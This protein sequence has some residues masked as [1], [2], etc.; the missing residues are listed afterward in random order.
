MLAQ[1]TWLKSI[2]GPTSSQRALPLK[3]VWR[4]CIVRPRP[5]QLA[6][7]RPPHARAVSRAIPPR[8]SG[9]FVAP[10]APGLL[11][12][13][14]RR[15]AR[16]SPLLVLLTCA[17][18]VFRPFACVAHRSFALAARPAEGRCRSH[19]YC[20]T[21]DLLTVESLDHH[22]RIESLT[23]PR[24]LM[25]QG[26]VP[27]RSHL[28]LGEHRLSE[29]CCRRSAQ[30]RRPRRACRSRRHR[31][32]Q[33][34]RQQPWDRSCRSPRPRCRS[35]RS[36]GWHSQYRGTECRMQQWTR[37]MTSLITPSSAMIG[38]R[39]PRR[40]GDGEDLAEGL[41]VLAVRPPGHQGR[42]LGDRRGRRRGAAAGG[43]ARRSLGGALRS[44]VRLQASLRGKP[45]RSAARRAEIG[46]RVA[47]ARLALGRRA[48]RHRSRHR[49]DL[50]RR[51]RGRR[52]LRR[53]C[54]RRR[55]LRRRHRP[56]RR[57]QD[58]EF[59]RP[60][61]RGATSRGGR[62]RKPGHGCATG[63]SRAFE[64]PARAR[65]ARSR[66]ETDLPGGGGGV[67]EAQAE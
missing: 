36:T 57:P 62:R 14:S 58:Q 15:L 37:P 40:A 59:R 63:G 43:L 17:L 19:S 4:F 18:W 53:L 21:S 27:R 46:R 35:P 23:W 9:A 65:A 39:R 52:R 1:A 54:G 56:R 24:P 25:A 7:G 51:H 61:R 32:R 31:C 55:R 45:R 22:C 16:E 28:R 49:R 44:A 47:E 8:R 66:G 20:P 12:R 30:P 60:R 3:Q 64:A 29:C 33:R 41:A 5:T 2:R 50:R 67:T 13:P 10:L 11:C 48:G 42:C 38:R 6:V 34:G 26:Q